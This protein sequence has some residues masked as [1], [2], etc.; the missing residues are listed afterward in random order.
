MN[1]RRLDVAALLTELV[2]T[3]LCG[4]LVSQAFEEEASYDSGAALA[5]NATIAAITILWAV[6][7][8]FVL[9]VWIVLRRRESRH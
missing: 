9:V 5:Q 8:V 4:F 2:W 3:V 1:L 7:S 6:G